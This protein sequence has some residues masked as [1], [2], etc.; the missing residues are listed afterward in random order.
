MVTSSPI[1]LSQ[2]RTRQVAQ[3]EQIV[4]GPSGAALVDRLAALGIIVNQSVR[5]LRTA[6]WGGPLHIL[7]GATTEIAIRRCEADQ[8]WVRHSDH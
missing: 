7:V 4:A 8:I 2:L 3:V 1:T 5:V 6:R